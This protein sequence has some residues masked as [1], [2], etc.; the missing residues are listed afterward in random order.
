MIESRIY[1]ISLTAVNLLLL[2]LLWIIA[3]LPI[4]T[5]FPSTIAVFGV[6][7]GWQSGSP[8]TVVAPFIQEFRRRFRQ[9]T[10]LGTLWVM[11]GTGIISTVPFIG[12][13]GPVVQ[14]LS[15]SVVAFIVFIYAFTSVFIPIIMV[16]FNLGWRDLL[17]VSFL[18]SIVHY[19]ATLTCLT[20]IISVFVLMYISP[21]LV[22]T[23]CS[24]TGYGFFQVYRRTVLASKPG[25][26]GIPIHGV[27]PASP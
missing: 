9:S 25:V 21:V 1:Q 11:V 12:A 6:V 16:S 7:R 13:S 10:L 19:K 27:G 2:N 3:S 22:L 23:A 26:V 15:A 8:Q 5:I 24:I 18:T 20:Y 4:V 17:R 14:F